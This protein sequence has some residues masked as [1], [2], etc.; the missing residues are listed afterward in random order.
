MWVAFCKGVTTAHSCC[1][2]QATQNSA[3][4][5]KRKGSVKSPGEGNDLSFTQ[6]NRLCHVTALL[7]LSLLFQDPALPELDSPERKAQ[8]WEEGPNSHS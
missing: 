7:T 6:N 8:A 2:L 1:A 3:P 4:L 5:G